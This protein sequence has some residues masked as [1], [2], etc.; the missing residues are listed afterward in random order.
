MVHTGDGLRGWS[1]GWQPIV[2]IQAELLEQA[3]QN[4]LN[5]VPVVIEGAS[6]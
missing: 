5:R 2:E 4:G 3:Y 1:S 6:L